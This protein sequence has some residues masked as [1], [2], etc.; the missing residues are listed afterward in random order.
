MKNS[1]GV[2]ATLT[3]ESLVLALLESIEGMSKCYDG[4]IAVGAALFDNGEKNLLDSTM[5]VSTK[6]TITSDSRPSRTKVK[7]TLLPLLITSLSQIT[8]K[9]LLALA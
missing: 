4:L 8:G 7:T 2:C 6:T 1:M 5:S 3:L 9:V